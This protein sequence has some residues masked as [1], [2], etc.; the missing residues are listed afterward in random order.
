MSIET[1]QSL[2]LTE[3]PPKESNSA[4]KEDGQGSGERNFLTEETDLVEDKPFD[5]PVCVYE[6]SWPEDD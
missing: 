4:P 2:D 6:S 1:V 3:S 5:L